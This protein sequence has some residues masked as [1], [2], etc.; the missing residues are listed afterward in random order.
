[1]ITRSQVPSLSLINSY[2]IYS[3]LS[4]EKA[5]SKTIYLEQVYL[6]MKFLTKLLQEGELI[7]LPLRCGTF[8]YIGKHVTPEI[9]NNDRIKKLSVDWVKTKEARKQDKEAMIFHFNEHS[10]G[11]RYKLNWSKRDV[12]IRNKTYYRFTQTRTNKRELAS[13]I[14]EG[15][16]FT[17]VDKIK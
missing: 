12:L 11:I 15:T 8:Q 14:K 13:L 3:E 16:E 4:K 5:H 7:H 2:D 10:N 9:I 1:M 6:L 17:V